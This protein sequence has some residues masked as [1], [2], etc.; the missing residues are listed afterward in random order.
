MAT[1]IIFNGQ[2]YASSIQHSSITVNGRT[3]ESVD[4]MPALVRLLYQHAIGQVDANRS[5]LPASAAAILGL[6]TS[7]ALDKTGRSLE[8]VIQVLLGIVAVVILAGAVFLMFKSR[9]Q[10]RIYVAIAALV[11][12]GAVDSQ[13]RRLVRRRMPFS[14]E[15]TAKERRYNVVSLVLML[16]AAVVLIGLALLL[17]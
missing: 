6:N 1:R 11:V 2:E 15:T 16:V 14:L 13:V 7:R 4:A 8:R 5:A 9:I 10:E 3:Y 17:P 12:L